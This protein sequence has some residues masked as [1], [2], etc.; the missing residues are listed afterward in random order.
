[1]MANEKREKKIK[2]RKGLF[3]HSGYK[4][5][6]C[7]GTDTD[8]ANGITIV[9]FCYDCDKVIKEGGYTV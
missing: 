3:Y 2:M 5:P 8:V 1:M 7:G 6:F 4:C 9:T